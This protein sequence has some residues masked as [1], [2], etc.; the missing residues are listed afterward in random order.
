MSKY[1]PIRELLANLPSNI[2]EKSFSFIEIEKILRAKLPNSA[3]NHRQWW[4][5]PTSPKNHSHAQSWLAAGWKVATVNQN[6]QW[7]RFRRSA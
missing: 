4:E 3:Y 2:K 5:N 6:E 1:D 7:I